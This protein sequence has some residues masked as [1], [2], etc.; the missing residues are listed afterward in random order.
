MDIAAQLEESAKATTSVARGIRQ[1]QLSQA[2]PCEDWD[3][4]TL[5]NHLV[6][7]LE[8]FAARAE[9]KPS[10]PPKPAP[11]A[12]YEET[13]SRLEGAA[14]A[15]VE[16]WQRPGALEQK[17]DS[18]SGAMPASTLATMAMSEMLMH[19][20]DLARATGQQ[21]RVDDVEVDQL[22]SEM[23]KVLPAGARQPA[24]GPETLPRANAAP[25]DR[26]AAF[27]GRTP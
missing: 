24:F 1:D 3:V 25:I 5:I 9:G 15:T 7:T 19:G 8:Y 13:I 14:G 10:G 22:L 23:K 18:G 12:P 17:I 27:L 21:L 2:T 26:L 16:A 4:E 6:G 11:K 20:W